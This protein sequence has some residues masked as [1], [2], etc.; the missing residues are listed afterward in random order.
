MS[1]TATCPRCGEPAV[2]Q[3]GW[4]C[5][6]H[7]VISPLWGPETPDYDALIEHL[8][9]AGGLPSWIPWPLKEGGAISDFGS[10]VGPSASFATCTF[11]SDVEG[12]VEFTVLTE[13]PGV[14]LGARCAGVP[15]WQ[16]SPDL[17][18]QPRAA[19]VRIDGHPIAL[20][21]VS[22]AASADDAADFARGPAPSD[23][24]LDRSVFVGEAEGRWLWVVLRPASAALLL[25]DDWSLQDLGALGAAALLDLP[26]RTAPRG[27]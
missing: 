4:A 26:F 3:R 9:R 14:G 20:W 8:G 17:R 19:S 12:L 6:L 10:V 18:V 13:E 1:L 25:L 27:W 7:G 5:P 15:G 22:T 16:P 23:E 21:P 11:M 24:L 2:D